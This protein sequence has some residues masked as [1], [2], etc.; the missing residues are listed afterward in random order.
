MT[1][2]KE[3]ILRA[4]MAQSKA[5]TSLSSDAAKEWVEPRVSQKR[6]KHIVGVAQTARE[7]ALL[8][9]C[10]PHAAELAGWL[11]DACKET[12]DKV[13]VE[14]ARRFGLTLHPAEE[15]NG[16]LLHGPVA[17]EVVRRE[18]GI[19]DLEFLNAIREH[20]LGAIAMSTLSKVV[21]L[22]DAIE[23]GRPVGDREPIWR[24]L[25]DYAKED[26]AAGD[27]GFALNLAVQLS[28]DIGLESLIA[29]GRPI[30]PKTVDVRNYYLEINAAFRKR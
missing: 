13:L 5:L 30:H 9:G 29:S 4:K 12:K 19:E 25:K 3:A 27:F 23:P 21:F 26:V 6:F 28:C 10:D 8:A 14:E 7:L 16:H 15:K 20:T 17:A 22:A 11:H 2:E 24:V 18:L 1:A